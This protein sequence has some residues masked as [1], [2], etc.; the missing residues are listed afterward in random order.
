[1]RTHETFSHTRLFYRFAILVIVCALATGLLF[2]ASQASSDVDVRGPSSVSRSSAAGKQGM[3][4]TSKQLFVDYLA[5]RV[6]SLLRRT[7]ARAV[8][9]A[10][11]ID[12][13]AAD[14]TTAKSSF[15][16]GETVCAKTDGVDLQFPGGRFVNWLDPSLEVAY[17]GSGVTDITTNPQTFTYTPTVTGTWK[18]TIA[19]TG[20]ISQTPA[21]FTVNPAPPLATYAAD[22]A[23]PKTV[24]NYGDTVCAKATGFGNTL[25]RRVGWLDPAGYFRE[26]NGIYFTSLA[27]DPQSVSFVLPAT[28]TSL[29][30]DLVTVDNR[31]KWRVNVLS[32]RGSAQASA[33]FVL[34]GP[35]PSADLSVTEGL[36]T[37]ASTSTG[38]EITYVV[39]V[40]NQG[41]NDAAN[42]VLTNS[43]P[44]N[45][46]FQ[47]VNQTS[48]PLFSCSGTDPVICTIGN[49]PVSGLAIF[50]LTYVAGAAGST[51]SATTSVTSSTAEVNAT[52]NGAVSPSARVPGGDPG[53]SCALECPANMV[54][55][56]NTEQN[57]IRGAIVTF[58]VEP[59]GSC[60]AITTEPASGSFFSLGITTVSSFSAQ[61]GGAC[62]FTVTVVE[63][64]PPAIEC[65][66]DQTVAAAAGEIETSVN[67]GT[68]TATGDNVQVEGIRSDNRAVTDPYPVGTTTITWRATDAT[69]RTAS[70]NQHIV[71]TSNDAPTI[72]C[73]ANQT[74]AAPT[75]TCQASV[76]PGTPTTTGSGVTVQGRRSDLLEVTDP[77]PSGLTTITWTA[78]DSIGRVASCT[79]TINVTSTGDTTPPTLNTPADVSALTSSCSALLDDE[80]GVATASDDCSSSV[81][82][83]RSGVPTF[84]CP[85]PSDPNRQCESFVFPVGITTITYTATDSAGN[86][87]TGTQRVTVI[88]SPTVPPTVTAPADITLNTGPGATSCGLVV[89]NATLGSAMAN[90]NCAGVTVTR[91]GVPA[92]NN[93][94]VG[95]TFITYTATDASGNTASATQKVTV[96]DNTPP[97]LTVPAATNTTASSCQAAI[98]NV[99]TGSTAGDNCGTVTISQNPTAGTSVGLGTHT[100]TVT[101]ID[102]HGN[103]TSATTTFT[104]NSPQLT[105][106]GPANMWIGL[107]NSDDVGTK[108]DLLA[109]TF[110][111]GVL[112]GSGQLNDVPGG[113]SGFNNAVQRTIS[114]ALSG[115]SAGFCTGDTMS[116]RLSV[117][118]AAS[119]SHVSGTA[120]LWFHDA[121]ANSRFTTTINGVTSDNY[122][123]SGFVLA[124]TA[125]PGPK[126]TIDV[127]VNRNQGGNPFKPFGTWTKTF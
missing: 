74:V 57:N 24:F 16:L 55:N 33:T 10:E 87:T 44:A 111:N 17:G 127:L 124:S 125:G 69:G 66:A 43:T 67:P 36:A 7:P 64:A 18:A 94:P 46:T 52:D 85:I 42:V 25:N 23:T 96:I 29:T 103:S 86:S 116:F 89:S 6:G 60:G 107:K 108:F 80:L 9:L 19:E 72:Q 54:V 5:G 71:V 68:P 49:L 22:C 106:V 88:E 109:E 75:G 104:V 3:N 14:C 41:P 38:A 126:S 81:S 65:P 32:N 34:Q 110:K 113:S 28:E 78:T 95:N 98:P 99:V 37:A 8:T 76:D 4:S 59:F 53:T 70:C 40:S 27:S 11:S 82:I 90:D 114:M 118:V 100:I 15:V 115:G 2:S 61:G 93:F 63:A 1:M 117:R 31:G 112:V 105:S 45:A 83:T 122:L 62:S 50:E 79:Q 120:R 13:F 119:S 97:T 48:G 35:A 21:I 20:D 102:G 47:S 73:P 91:T 56:A 92:G 39:A 101:A 30:P 123:R 12:T 58:G 84:A 121:A 77:Y 51:L 26:N